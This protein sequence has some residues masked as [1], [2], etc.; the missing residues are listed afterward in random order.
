MV[1]DR[2]PSSGPAQRAD[3]AV[4]RNAVIRARPHSKRANPWR[5]RQSGKLRHV[6]A[7]DRD[8]APAPELRRS[9]RAKRAQ[10]R[11]SRSRVPAPPGGPAE[12]HRDGSAEQHLAGERLTDLEI[13][14]VAGDLDDP[15]AR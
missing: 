15:I 10:R 14:D 1:I 13:G 9:S 7:E 12:A 6:E 4:Q 2:R 3:Q 5:R 8:P 11:D